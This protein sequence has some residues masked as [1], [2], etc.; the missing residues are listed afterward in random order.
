MQGQTLDVIKIERLDEEI[1]TCQLMTINDTLEDF[2]S[3][4][5]CRT[6]DIVVRRFGGVLFDIICDDEALL[7]ND[8][9]L[10]TSWWQDEE[11]HKEGLF[12][13]LLLCHSDNEG[14]LTSA[15]END[16]LAVQKAYREVKTAE[17]LIVLLFHDIF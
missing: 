3:Q 8:P 7:K 4:I 14:E 16:L 10:P 6:I 11:G 2:Y 13:T 17:G 12:G 9:G 15:T 1:L 5:G